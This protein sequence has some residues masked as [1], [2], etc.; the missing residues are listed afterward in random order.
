MLGMIDVSGVVRVRGRVRV[1][2]VTETLISEIG[3]LVTGQWI[4]VALTHNGTIMTLY[5]AGVEVSSTTLVGTVDTDATMAVAI[6][7][8]PPGAGGRFFDGLIDEVHIYQRSLSSAEVHALADAPNRPPLASPDSYQTPIDTQLLVNAGSGV[9]ANDTD[10]DGDDL[11]AILV[12]D[13]SNGTLSLASD[14]SFT[15]DPTTSYDGPD[16]FTYKANDGALDSNTASVTLTVGDPPAASYPNTP[17]EVGITDA[18]CPN[19]DAT[20][21]TTSSITT[22]ANNQT[23]SYYQ[24]SGAVLVEHNDVTIDC[25]RIGT[26]GTPSNATYGID[27]KGGTGGTGLTVTNTEVFMNGN[28][29]NGN[30]GILTQKNDATIQD[31][32]FRGA[33]DEIFFT[34]SRI[35]INHNYID[36]MMG[37][38][39]ETPHMDTIQTT[40]TATD[41]AITNNYLNGLGCSDSE[42]NTD[43]HN[44]ANVFMQNAYGPITNVLISGN[45]IH[46]GGKGIHIDEDPESKPAGGRI[47]EVTITNNVITKNFTRYG[48]YIG[49]FSWSPAGPDCLD[50]SGN[51]FDDETAWTTGNVGS[52]PCTQPA[53]PIP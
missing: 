11:T 1:G 26:L 13:V 12:A 19:W 40:G 44:S 18:A 24:L 28:K 29:P 39:A 35:L 14:G 41:V 15:Y 25:V 47:T 8:Q 2:G 21:T 32:Y 7:A 46:G 20:K 33:V 6:G 42:H 30:K 52:P 36:C 45:R 49:N 37:R 53:P 34:G 23:I 4:H 43:T 38:G 9:L 50:W 48:S 10:Q 27:N 5:I 51:T 31:S 3:E 22:T 16:G 17:S